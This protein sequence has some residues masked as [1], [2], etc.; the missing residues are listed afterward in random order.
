MKGQEFAPGS[1]RQRSCV[2]DMSAAFYVTRSCRA[3]HQ[4]KTNE[5]R[6]AR[7]T[8]EDSSRKTREL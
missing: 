4:M 5:E 7:H 1:E 2:R 8:M 6:K 3:C